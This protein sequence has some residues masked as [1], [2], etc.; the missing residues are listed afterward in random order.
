MP[1]TSEQSKKRYIDR[2]QKGL[3]I[4]CGKHPHTD[5]VLSCEECRIKRQK[6]DRNKTIKRRKAGMCIRCGK[7]PV[8]PGY[9]SCSRCH[10]KDLARFRKYYNDPSTGLAKRICAYNQN[11]R[12]CRVKHDQ[13]IACGKELGSMDVKPNGEEYYIECINCRERDP[14]TTFITKEGYRYAHNRIQRAKKFQHISD[15]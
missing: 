15:G 9:A 14:A 10:H 8:I 3:C 12:D 1:L 7:H 6:F 4:Q 11:K 5:G 2:K 13:C